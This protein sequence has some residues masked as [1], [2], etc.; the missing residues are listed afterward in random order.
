MTST[1]TPRAIIHIS[2]Y[3]KQDSRINYS[4]RMYAVIRRYTPDVAESRTNECFADLTGLRTFFK[5]TY[6]EI[7]EKIKQDLT[8]EIGI[9]FVIKIASEKAFETAKETTKKQ[10]SISTYKEINTF[11]AG[12]TLATRKQHSYTPH[13]KKRFVVPFIGKVS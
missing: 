7:A 8:R 6:A 1:K 2:A 12:S 11:F 5:M 3:G 4:R 13:Q 10:K 9:R